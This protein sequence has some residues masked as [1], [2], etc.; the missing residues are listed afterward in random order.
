[1]ASSVLVEVFEWW[2]A[3]LLGGDA[4]SDYLGSQGDEWD[5]QKDMALATAGAIVA[6]VVTA[7]S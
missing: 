3:E 5:T 7:A 4:G 1:M 2:A 6:M